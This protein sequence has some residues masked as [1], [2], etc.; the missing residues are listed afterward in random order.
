M[1]TKLDKVLPY[2][3]GLPC[4]KSQDSLI[5]W[6]Y[7]VSWQIENVVSPVSN[8][9][10]TPDSV[11]SGLL[12]GTN[13]Q[14]ITSVL[15]KSQFYSWVFIHVRIILLILH[16]A[17][18]RLL[19]LVREKEPQI[20]TFLNLYVTLNGIQGRIW[21]L[22]FVSLPLS[23]K[24][25]FFLLDLDLLEKNSLSEA[26]FFSKELSLL[27]NNINFLTSCLQTILINNSRF[28][29]WDKVHDDAPVKF[30][31]KKFIPDRQSA[32]SDNKKQY[33]VYIQ[34]SQEST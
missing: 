12:Q 1:T 34:F 15:V 19:W 18:V 32:P 30:P 9:L 26:V 3:I 14:Q 17:T 11:V 6:L 28:P 2:G 21:L 5:T 7:I 29:I 16:R 24:L 8:A 33:L 27:R 20:L 23:C 10:W 22:N 31:I 4:T 13:T 25:S